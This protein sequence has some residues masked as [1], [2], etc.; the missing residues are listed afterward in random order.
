M[1]ST[2]A[3]WMAVAGSAACACVPVLLRKTVLHTSLTWLWLNCPFF[4]HNN[5][6][7]PVLKNWLYSS[8]GGSLTTGS[9]DGRLLSVLTAWLNDLLDSFSL[10]F[11]SGDALYPVPDL[12]VEQE[13]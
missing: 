11:P 4:L 8:K 5:V 6:D 1:K 3:V 2:G 7:T 10:T 13:V 9:A 12:V